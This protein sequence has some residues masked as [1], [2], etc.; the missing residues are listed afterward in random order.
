MTN[1]DFMIEQ[2]ILQ[3]DQSISHHDMYDYLHL[4]QKGYTK[5]NLSSTMSEPYKTRKAKKTPFF[6]FFSRW[7]RSQSASTAT[8]STSLSSL[9]LNFFISV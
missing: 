2:Y 7:L 5:V 6:V 4:T 9:S 8:M 1:K 3:V